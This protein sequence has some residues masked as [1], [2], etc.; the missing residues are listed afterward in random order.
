MG[1]RIKF[2]LKAQFAILS[3]FLICATAAVS[4]YL[5]FRRERQILQTQI[6]ARG[7]GVAR[8]LASNCGEAL[9]PTPD[10]LYLIT[11][12]RETTS[13][14]TIGYALV[15]DE[16]GKI[17]AHNDLSVWGT[18]YI[19]ASKQIRNPADNRTID[20][21]ASR[22]GR[23]FYD[24]SAPILVAK[25]SQ[26]G[27]VHVGIPIQVVGDL[28]KQGRNRLAAVVLALLGVGIAVSMIMAGLI[29]RP[30]QMLARGA[31]RIGSGDLE[32]RIKMSRRDEFGLLANSFNLMASKL[33]EL[34]L[35]TF[36]ML[37]NALEAKD[38][39][40]RGHTERVTRLSV[41][42][43]KKMR[44]PEAEIQ[45]IRKA[46]IVHDIGK[47]G[48]KESILNKPGVLTDDERNHIK[49][50]VD[51]GTH[52]LK[53]VTSMAKVA[54]YVSHHHERY[55]GSGYPSGL[56]REKIPLGAR[57]IAV[58][59]AFDAMT[60]DRP[61]RQALARNSAIA[62]L[63]KSSGTQFDPEIVRTFLQV[64]QPSPVDELEQIASD[65]E[66]WASK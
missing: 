56:A 5:A 19:P 42:I 53:P 20:I 4:G 16:A 9:L 62:E 23:L 50:H 14:E 21:Y 18:E 3:I 57:I 66:A 33:G 12:L 40:S 55:D 13:D 41:E 46:A 15:V 34:Y 64:L 36:Q 51:W 1:V 35:N 38:V 17:V 45:T 60:S 65:E 63:K 61:N 26:M 54:S 28:I 7:E 8:S 27:T 2:G 49:S 44:L 29:M 31:E 24:F 52:I 6:V 43:A 48:I 22:N 32:Y 10:D 11:L 37:A 25:G 59:D 47:I 58:A 39:Y 30:I